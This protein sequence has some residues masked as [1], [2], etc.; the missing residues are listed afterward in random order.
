MFN[1]GQTQ[2]GDCKVAT[3]NWPMRGH[4]HVGLR[5]RQMTPWWPSCVLTN[6]FVICQNP[7]RVICDTEEVEKKWR[8]NENELNMMETFIFRQL[9]GLISRTRSLQTF[10]IVVSPTFNH[11]SS[12][13][14]LSHSPGAQDHNSFLLLCLRWRDGA[15]GGGESVLL[16]QSFHFNPRLLN[17]QIFTTIR[18]P[19]LL[20]EEL[21][22]SC[23]E[24]NMVN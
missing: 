10:Y 3:E 19:K 4:A 24:K 7:N 11:I 9:T 8:R 2:W 17:R 21:F 5:K 20:H 16:S 15:G 12:S 18:A 23:C 1:Q 14:S 13:P 6:V 22:L